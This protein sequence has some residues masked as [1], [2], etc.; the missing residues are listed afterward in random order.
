MHD[1][2]SS[3]SSSSSFSI[4]ERARAAVREEL[5][6]HCNRC[7][8]QYFHCVWK[9]HKKSRSTLKRATFTP[10]LDRSSGCYGQTQLWRIFESLK[11]T[12]DQCYQT[13]QF[14]WETGG[15]CFLKNQ[16]RHFEYFSNT[17]RRREKAIGEGKR[18]LGDAK[19]DLNHVCVWCHVAQPKSYLHSKQYHNLF[20]SSF[21]FF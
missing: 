21:F 7:D 2:S 13:G 8:K 3:Y 18:R 16:W 4:A 6:S 11:L 15:K 10:W 19:R 12:V 1:M 9:S 5:K 20:L 14:Q 17:Y